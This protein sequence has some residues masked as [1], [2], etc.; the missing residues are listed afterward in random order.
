MLDGKITRLVLNVSETT[1]GPNNVYCEISSTEDFTSDIY[2]SNE[3]QNHLQNTSVLYTF[4]GVPVPVN[5]FLYLRFVNQSGESQSWAAKL[6]P[7][8]Q[9]GDDSYCMCGSTKN[10]WLPNIG[11]TTSSQYK[12]S[13][14]AYIAALEARVKAL[15]DAQ[16]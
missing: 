5:G 9:T 10:N 14:G 12:S 6:Y 8:L 2:R 11:I 16:L 13:L 4:N 7:N 1:A 15:E 3:M